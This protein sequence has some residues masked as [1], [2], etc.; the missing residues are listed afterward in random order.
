MP[1]LTA[2]DVLAK[3]QRALS[4]SSVYAVR[5]L[6]IR[7]D[8]NALVLTGELSSFYH[9]Q[10]AQEIVRQHA[11]GMEVVNSVRVR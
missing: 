2:K 10:V 6:K 11:E 3:A 9:M 5:D 7:S 4:E 8:G 1:V